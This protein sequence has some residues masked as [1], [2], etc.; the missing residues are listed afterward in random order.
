M[1]NSKRIRQL[2]TLRLQNGAA[3]LVLVTGLL[4]MTGYTLLQLT[5]ANQQR[6][7][8]QQEI[9]RSLAAAKNALIAYAVT[10]VDHYGHNTRGG[11]G[12]LPCP[13]GS[14]YGSPVG[15]CGPDAIGYL[16]GVWK[17]GKKQIDIDHLERFLDRDLWYSVSA[18]YRF[19]PAF[20]PLNSNQS[21]Y[22]LTV[23]GDDQ[24]VAV[25]IA[26]GPPLPGQ[27]RVGGAGAISD[28]LEGENADGDSVFRTAGNDRLVTITRSELMPL[29]ERRVLGFARDWLAEYRLQYGYYPFAA[30]F[31]DPDGACQNGLT[32]GR[33]P[34]RAGDCTEVPL[35]DLRSQFV[36]K[37]RTVSE[38]WFGN[39]HW[40]DFIYYQSDPGC[41]PGAMDQQCTIAD[42]LVLKVNDRG[43][44]VL[45][46]GAGSAIATELLPMGQQRLRGNDEPGNEQMMHYFDTVSLLSSENVFDLRYMD[47]AVLSGSQSNDHYQVIRP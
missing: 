35:G 34:M 37:G 26:P 5:H 16:P 45:L 10:Y 29:I 14:R 41:L 11:V 27:S 19:N 25:I 4:A 15:T 1:S 20:N 36:P 40:S 24:V 46:I 23:D 32:R 43:A 3:L 13:S 2:Q 12:R 9:T 42:N 33:L 38:T 8:H 17:R 18:D 39:Y 31:G 6:F 22:L 7:A 47:S 21:D 30:A 44:Q 28:Y